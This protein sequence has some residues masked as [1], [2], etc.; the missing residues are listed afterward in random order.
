MDKP[1]NPYRPGTAIYRLMDEDWSDKNTDEI[2]KAIGT[3]RGYVHHAMFR[4][5]DETGYS[6]E[7][8]DRRGIYKK[9]Q[10]TH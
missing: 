2:A 3:I 5:R 8:I 10:K 7:Y 1:K 4:I 9:S 6:I